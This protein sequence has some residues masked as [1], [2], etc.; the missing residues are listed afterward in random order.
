MKKIFLNLL[1]SEDAWLQERL[2]ANGIDPESILAEASEAQKKQDK[3]DK[4]FLRLARDISKWSKDPST[5]VGA[6]IVDE[7]QRIVSIGY[8]GF[9]S[10]IRDTEERLNDR[11]TKYELTIH[12]EMNA[13]LFANRQV[14][15][16]TLY[17]VPLPPCTRC[18]VMFIQAGI[19]RVVAPP[20]A[21]EQKD[22][23]SESVE[24][25]TSLFREAGIT[26]EEVREDGA[27]AADSEA[28]GKE[29]G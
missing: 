10:A 12:G 11:D 1:D 4:R 29:E 22:R 9:P 5:Q 20:L 16:C 17:T 7:Q 18:A 23:W 2:R 25:S 15:G 8:N 13:L 26:F 28:T 19:S 6:V 3:W 24:R 27:V 21:E 14:R